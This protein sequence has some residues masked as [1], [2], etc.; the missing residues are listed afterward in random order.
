MA[1]WLTM[2]NRRYPL[3]P[4]ISLPAFRPPGVDPIAVNKYMEKIY[5][6]SWTRILTEDK[7]VDNL[8]EILPTYL[9][10]DAVG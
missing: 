7:T 4:H 8:D 1:G 9:R 5:K 3:R 2:M 10:G 6:N